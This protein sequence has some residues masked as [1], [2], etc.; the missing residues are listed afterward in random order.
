MAAMIGSYEV[1]VCME[2]SSHSHS[3]SHSQ[4]QSLPVFV[5][6][7]ASGEL[8]RD[9]SE[10]ASLPR[11]LSCGYCTSRMQCLQRSL[12]DTPA[13]GSF[14]DSKQDT[15][16]CPLSIEVSRQPANTPSVSSL[17]SGLSVLGWKWTVLSSL[18]NF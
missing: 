10:C 3:H 18:A 6:D 14:I 2:N 16:Q 1:H 4:S 17:A 13:A 9:C 15:G 7:C 5:Y 8:S 11:E 12:C